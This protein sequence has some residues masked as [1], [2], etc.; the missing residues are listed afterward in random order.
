M[1]RGDGG[2][3][4]GVRNLEIV[5]EIADVVLKSVGG[6]LGVVIEDQSGSAGGIVR[7]LVDG[8][9]GGELEIGGVELLA[10]E[11]TLKEIFRIS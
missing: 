6:A 8:A 5:G 3:E 9:T 2:I 10:D 4:R 1:E 11:N 7:R